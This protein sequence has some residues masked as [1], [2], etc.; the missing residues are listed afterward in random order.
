MLRAQLHSL[1]F[2]LPDKCSI[3]T[4]S[5]LLLGC[6]FIRFTSIPGSRNRKP[7]SDV[8]RRSWSRGREKTPEGGGGVP[9]QVPSALR[10]PLQALARGAALWA[11]GNGWV[12]STISQCLYTYNYLLWSLLLKGTDPRDQLAYRA[13]G[14]SLYMLAK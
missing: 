9:H 5:V 7:C 3:T 14:Y 10:W 2:A 4:S 1:S 6:T 8:G 12:T 13:K 11:P